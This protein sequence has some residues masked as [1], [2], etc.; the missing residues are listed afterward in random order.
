M[1]KNF[2]I[3]VL[4]F[5]SLSSYSQLSFDLTGSTTS[6]GNNCFELTPDVT[7]KVGTAW[8]LNTLDLNKDFTIEFVGYWGIKDGTGADGMALVFSTQSK[9]AGGSG[10]GI[11]YTGITP[12]LC[13][14]FD[15]Y[16]NSPNAD[17]TYDHIALQANGNAAHNATNTLSG[18]VQA[19][20]TNINIE[21]GNWHVV[22]VIWIAKTKTFSVYFDCALRLT[23]SGDIAKNIF[24]GNSSVYW[25]FTSST[26]SLSNQH[27]ICFSYISFVDSLKDTT[28]CKGS[29]VQ[30]N[31]RVGASY[32][33][34]PST[35]LSDP[36]IQNPIATPDS[37]TTY[38]I[39]IQDACGS[40][41]EDSVTITV[42]Q[43]VAIALPTDTEMCMNNSITLSA[44]LNGGDANSL[45]YAWSNG[46]GNTNAITVSPKT[47]TSYKIIA[48]DICS[49]DSATTLLTIN[50][51]PSISISS[52]TTTCKGLA[53][54]ITASGALTYNWGNT[55]TSNPLT[56]YPNTDSSLNVIGTDVNGCSNTASSTI[57]VLPPPAISING[58]SSI[59]IGN[60]ATLTAIGAST[61]LWSNGS[62]GNSITVAPNASTTYKVIGT[63]NNGCYD[64]SAFGL[65]VNPAITASIS[66]AITMC[67]GNTTTLTVSGGNTY[68]WGNGNTNSSISIQPASDTSCSVTATDLNGCTDQISIDITVHPLPQPIISGNTT[69]CEGE[70][71]LLTAS[72]GTAYVWSTGNQTSQIT[73]TPNASENL[74]LTATDIYGCTN[75]I[76]TAIIVNPLPAVSIIGTLT[77]CEGEP[78]LLTANG[79]LLYSWCN[80]ALGNTLTVNPQTDTSYFV[81]T[82]DANNCSNSDTVYLKVNPNPIISLTGDSVICQ[83]ET[84][85]LSASGGLTYKWDNGETQ[86]TATYSPMQSSIINVIATD[87]N[88]CSSSKNISL[89]VNEIPQPEL[90]ENILLCT[91]EHVII[92]PG[93]FSSYQWQDGSSNSIY[94]IVDTGN[95]FVSVSNQFGCIASD[96]IKVSPSNCSSI[97]IP[98]SFTPNGDGLNDYFN[99][100]GQNIISFH[101]DI[102]NRWG[103]TIYTTDQIANTTNDKLGWNGDNASDNSYI[104]NINYTGIFDG[105]I[106]S[107]NKKGLVNLIK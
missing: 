105:R 106:Y 107:A 48:S 71:T 84:T 97:Y 6:L 98:N 63:D 47:N 40:T 86:N 87:Q 58:I 56:I 9:I 4:S 51:L 59:C 80:G 25:G 46:L 72:G 54:V 11:G 96:T 73:L 53:A 32:T 33:W 19:S 52:P 2:T 55:I 91:D 17:P 30:L 100:I 94:N 24:S 57:K 26:G 22:K 35:Y 79:G 21:D 101:M 66:G 82:T 88:N 81:T 93:N 38:H 70:S 7:W 65:S 85:L 39:Y 69:L 10:V 20:A 89:I 99:P 61:Y 23:Y 76:E 74:Q 16:Y 34:S 103:N 1:R 64:S 49:I 41:Q 42:I 43:P 8:F 83:G 78:T 60:S 50:S 45:S 18:P 90:G 62:K 5:L 28:V 37:T 13:L 77:I 75:T 12:S 67:E 14:E 95:Y 44:I 29:S 104:W 102:V 27:E 36:T 15:T 3:V 31:T 92:S 68:L